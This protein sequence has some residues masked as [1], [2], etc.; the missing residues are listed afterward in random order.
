MRLRLQCS[1]SCDGG[2]LCHALHTAHTATMSTSRFVSS[3]IS[4]S[5][6]VVS[7]NAINTGKHAADTVMSTMNRYAGRATIPSTLRE[8]VEV[9]GLSGLFLGLQSRI[10]WSGSII[11]GQFLLYDVCKA[12]LH[13]AS[14]DL[15]VFLD[16]IGSV[17]L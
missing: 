16:V 7:L 8:I 15:K 5:L 17:G 14:D 12:A 11:S 4:L 9:R 10:V 6:V 3:P 13:V 1:H 2:I